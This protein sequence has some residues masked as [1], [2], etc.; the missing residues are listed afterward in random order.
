MSFSKSSKLSL[1]IFSSC[2]VSTE[3][4]LRLF[5]WNMY[6]KRAM[7]QCLSMSSLLRYFCAIHGVVQC[8][9][10]CIHLKSESGSI[11]GKMLLKCHLQLPLFMSSSIVLKVIHYYRK[12]QTGFKWPFCRFEKHHLVVFYWPL[13]PSPFFQPITADLP[14]PS[15]GGG[16]RRNSFT[17]GNSFTLGKIVLHL[18]FEQ[19]F[20]FGKFKN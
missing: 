4:S 14:P 10:L 11:V 19:N 15:P 5:L 18:F 6:V 20:K 8:T 16:S 12:L 7:N 13:S 17:Q 9:V 2:N 1:I 3:N